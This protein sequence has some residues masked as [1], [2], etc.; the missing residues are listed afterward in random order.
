M[1]IEELDRQRLG[2]LVPALQDLQHDLGKYVCFETRFV[3][4]EAD[5]ASLRQALR[6]DLLATRRRGEQ[7]EAAWQVWA[8]LRPAGLDDDPDVGAI[9]A[10]VEALARADLGGARPALL[11]A[12]AQADRVRQATRSLALRARQAA[13]DAGLDPDDL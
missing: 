9:D 3:G 1:K 11:A 8:R 6:A 5:L 12:A 2:G 10:A 13:A 7:A 4:L